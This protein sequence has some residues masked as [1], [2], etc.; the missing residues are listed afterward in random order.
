MILRN[1]YDLCKILGISPSDYSEMSVA[2]IN[3][4]I[5]QIKKDLNDKDPFLLP[6]TS[7]I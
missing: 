4:F 5:E 7:M 3:F 1:S 2:K 6:H